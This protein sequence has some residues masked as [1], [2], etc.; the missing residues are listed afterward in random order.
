MTFPN[1]VSQ[2]RTYD[3]AGRL[4]AVVNAGPGGPIGG[5]TYTRDANGNPIDI[6]VYQG[7]TV[8]AAESMLVTYDNA[9]RVTRTCHTNTACATGNQT[10]WTYDRVGN[11]LTEK[12]G[13]AAQ[14]TY[15]YDAADQLTAITGPGAAGF[16]YNANGD[17]LTAGASSFTYNT[18]RQPTSATVAGITHVFTYD[19]NGNRA[20]VNSAGAITRELLDTNN[21]LPVL[22]AE[23]NPPGAVLRRYTHGPSVNRCDTPT[24]PPVDQAGISRSGRVG[25]QHHQPWWCGRRH[26]PV[27]HLG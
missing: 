9:D 18:A 22:V 7:A 25:H 19:G 21:P 17:Q 16:T 1:A 27:Q 3:R 23:R 15:T 6:D 4:A 11:R 8:N 24:P 20:A 5:F 13:A 2:S 12:I 26:L 10:T 14:S